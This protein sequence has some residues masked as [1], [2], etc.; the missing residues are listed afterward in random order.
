MVVKSNFLSVGYRFA[1][2][3]DANVWVDG[4]A[5]SDQLWNDVMGFEEIR[6]VEND[7]SSVHIGHVGVFV[8]L[9]GC[10]HFGSGARLANSVR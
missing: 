10:S 4:D 5:P 3:R 9:R 1:L 7:G 8:R 2:Q 6:N